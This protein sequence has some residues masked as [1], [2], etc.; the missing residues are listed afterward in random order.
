MAGVRGVVR[1]ARNERRVWVPR[2]T[3]ASK[4][5]AP[6]KIFLMRAEALWFHLCKKRKKNRGER[7][8]N[9]R[10]FLRYCPPRWRCSHTTAPSLVLN[11]KSIS[12]GEARLLRARSMCGSTEE[13]MSVFFRA[14]EIR[15]VVWRT[16]SSVESFSVD[17]AGA[18]MELGR[19]FVCVSRLLHGR[20]RCSCVS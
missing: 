13:K 3:L 1:E 19:V 12:L 14:C 7:E 2:E 17:K 18:M 9:V 6:P 11:T 10:H 8:R 15:R 20:W 4:V 5:S 16:S